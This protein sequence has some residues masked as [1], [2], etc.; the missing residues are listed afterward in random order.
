MKIKLLVV[1]FNKQIRNNIAITS[2]TSAARVFPDF[3]IIVWDNSIDPECRSKNAYY[4]QEHSLIYLTSNENAKLSWV[5]NKIIKEHQFDYLIISDDDSE[6]SEEYFNQ[7][8]TTLL[9]GHLVSVPQI[10][11]NDKLRSPAKMGLIVGKHLDLIK[12]GKHKDLIA[13]TSGMVISSKL[14]GIMIPVFDE[15]LTFYGVDTEFFLRLSK[16]NIA[17]NVMAVRLI[18]EMAMH[19]EEYKL[20]KKDLSTNFRYMNNKQATIY[21]CNKQSYVRGILAK[22]YYVLYEKLKIK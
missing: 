15:N 22:I 20:I 11:V 14:K 4:A 10:Y 17:L 7:L 21:I 18:H 19:G 2:A 13:I 5:Y 8:K 6:Y 1:I 9:E 12:P 16:Y 3:E